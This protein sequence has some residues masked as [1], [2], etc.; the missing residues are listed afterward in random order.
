MIAL[1]LT[2]AVLAVKPMP[3][4]KASAADAGA[5]PAAPAPVAARADLKDPSGKTVGK[6]E[7]REGKSGVVLTVELTSATAGAH[8][9]HFHDKGKCEGPKF[10][11]AGPHFNPSGGKHGLM[12][13]HGGHAGDLPNLYVPESGAVKAEIF[14]KGARLKDGPH[15]LLDA[16]GAALVVHAKADDYSTDPSGA[17]G[18]RVACGELK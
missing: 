3:P 15:P 13:E 14:V 10:E 18:D 4:P 8:A 5:P 6:V 7:L 16:D 17:S 12:S 9:M 1:S 11:S 2:L